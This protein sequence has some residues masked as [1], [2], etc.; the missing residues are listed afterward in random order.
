M[1]QNKKPL[2]KLPFPVPA[3]DHPEQVAV[4][5]Q[6][7]PKAENYADRTWAPPRGTRR[8]MGKR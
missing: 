8:S 7:R 4:H 1:S 6:V 2:V 5:N 3:A